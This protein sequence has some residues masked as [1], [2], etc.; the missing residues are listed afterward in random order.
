MKSFF[1]LLLSVFNVVQA[2]AWGQNGHRIVGQIASNH[3]SAKAQKAVGAI[4]QGQSIAMVS[5]FMDEI[6]SDPHY[7]SL[8]PW[9]YCTI[10]DGTSYA[11]PPSEGDVIQAINTYIKQL[12]SGKLSDIEE[13]F[14][15]KCLI[16][17]VGD[18]HQPLH[19]GNGQDKG[20]NEIKVTYFW[21]SSNLHRVW[22]S[23]IIDGQKLSYTEYVAWIDQ[24]GTQQ[25]NDWKKDDI[26]VWAGESVSYRP[27]VYDLPDHK[28]INYDYNYHNIH[29]VNKRLLQAGIR[30]AGL[31]E[32]I[33]N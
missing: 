21:E 25:V 26:M 33:Y 13:A 18:I 6:K 9:H 30:L 5:N 27:Q 19:V 23:G 4:L 17:L 11:G 24:E 20:G 2:L 28:K 7:D 32:D 31:L 8:S 16:H 22:D 10:P 12:K 14:A 29:I 3:M 1:I 15:L